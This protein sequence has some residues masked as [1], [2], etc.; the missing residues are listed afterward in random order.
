M[1]GLTAS[2]LNSA[3]TTGREGEVKEAHK[4]REKNGHKCRN[5][6]GWKEVQGRV[7]FLR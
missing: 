5:K 6:A 4:I 3:G 7:N 1:R 2:Y